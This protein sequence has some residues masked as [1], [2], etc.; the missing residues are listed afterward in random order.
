M[1]IGI[2][3]YSLENHD[4]SMPWSNPEVTKGPSLI[5]TGSKIEVYDPNN[6]FSEVFI[7]IF[8]S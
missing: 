5:G 7:N 6:S 4:E 3:E 8:A 1:T 2:G